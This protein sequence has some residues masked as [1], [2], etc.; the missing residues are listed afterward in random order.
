MKQIILITDHI[1]GKFL[2]VSVIQQ[3]DDKAFSKCS[4]YICYLFCLNHIALRKAKI[5]YNFGFLSVIG[6]K[7]SLFKNGEDLESAIFIDS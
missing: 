4:P 2:L 5:A 6:F 3:L 1:C 7:L